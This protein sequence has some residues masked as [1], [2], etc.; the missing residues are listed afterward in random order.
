[1][2]KFFSRF[3]FAAFLFCATAL[4]APPA[5][6]AADPNK[7]VQ[8]AV[9]LYEKGDYEKALKV[10][11]KVLHIDP[12]HSMAREYMLLCSQK[13]VE[14]KL[15]GAAAETLE[16]EIAAELH[17]Q[18]SALS[19]STVPAVLAAEP[20]PELPTDTPSV[21]RPKPLPLLDQSQLLTD[22]LR[23]RHLGLENIVQLQEKRGR[24]EVSLYMN[25]LFLPYS[26]VL[27]DESYVVLNHVA[28]RM[29]ANPKRKVVLKAIEPDSPAIR[30]YLPA[31]PSRRCTAVM[32]Y[33]IYASFLPEEKRL[34]APPN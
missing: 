29:K 28:Q 11:V 6:R 16:K 5:V 24:I 14:E 31:L 20:E 25:R 13:I 9:K 33:L 30:R 17:F 21:S 2:K 23:R 22:D 15:G 19:T 3:T 27:R 1:M 7:L 18:E 26:D 32:S 4:A 34:L 12:N 8:K 10:F